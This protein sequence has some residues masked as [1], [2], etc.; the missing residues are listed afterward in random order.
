MTE[1]QDEFDALVAKRPA[2]LTDIMEVLNIMTPMQQHLI[3]LS[4]EGR[5]KIEAEIAA[6]ITVDMPQFRGES[7][8]VA[9]VRLDREQRRSVYKICVP[10]TILFAQSLAQE[11]DNA[12]ALC[13]ALAEVLGQAKGVRP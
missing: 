8:Y 2:S 10:K 13:D 1:K 3:T 11:R 7:P 12:Q 9:F 5:R 6:G 4:D